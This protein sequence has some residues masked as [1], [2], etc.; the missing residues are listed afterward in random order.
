VSRRRSVTAGAF[1]ALSACLVACGGTNLHFKGNEEHD[2][3]PLFDNLGSYNHPITT[4]SPLAQKYFDQGLRL[5]YGFNHDEARRAFEEAARLDPD[6]VMA[7]WGIA[8]TLG[9]NYNLPGDP[10]RDR[11]AY[12]AVAKAQARASAASE[13]ERAYLSAIATRYADPPPTDRRSL[14]E[15]YA[16]AMQG[17]AQRYPDDLDAATL[18]AESMMD[19]QPWE[20][21]TRHGKPRAG[22]LEIVATLESVLRRA[23]DHPGANHYYIHAV[24]ASSQP[25]RGLSSADRLGRLVPGAGHLVHMPSHIYMRVGRYD[26]AVAANEQAIAVDEAYIES[27]KVQGVY[28]M[29]Y[30][31]HNIHFLWAAAAFDGRSAESVQAADK[32]ARQVPQDM[33]LSMPG[34]M[35]GFLAAPFLARVRFGKWEE[36]L[37]Q[38]AP[39]K[40]LQYAG[41]LW[42]YARGLAYLR[43]ARIREARAELSSLDEIAAGMPK[44]QVVTQVNQGSTLLSIASHTLA[45]EIAA[46]QPQTADEAVAQ[47]EE[48]VKLQDNL[49][50]MEPPDWYFPVRQA[51]GA[52]LLRAKRAREAEAVYRTDLEQNPENG[53][54]LFGLAASLRALKK[55]REASQVESRFDKAWKHSD[56]ALPASR[57]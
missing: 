44:D 4:K 15:A 20:L 26:D 34:G 31:P 25:E 7:Y 19:L 48:A 1:V 28:A 38:P 41:A 57:F 47:L 43:T 50:Y 55:T 16:Q 27:Q 13:R 30:Y 21:W 39:P 52:V 8:Y 17:L 10:S 29:M 18:Y 54:S 49:A 45:G 11:E 36:V 56:I 35:E 12:Q 42:H 2:G 22:T 23:P 9:P 51:L 46:I 40:S 3:V 53:W 32:L 5:V 37:A 33:L 14:D 6:A 24:E